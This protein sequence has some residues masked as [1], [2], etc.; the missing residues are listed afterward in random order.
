MIKSQTKDKLMQLKLNAFVEVLEEIT[1]NTSCSLS[2][3]EALDM[4][5][6]REMVLRDN[7]RL[8]RLLKTAKLRYPSACA[9]NIDYHQ[10]RQ[11][12][13]E[14]LRQLTHCQ[15]ISERRNVIFTGPTGTGK[16]YLACAIG[17]QA[18]Q[19]SHSVRY[20]RVT[21]L[22][23]LLRL[24]HADGSYN[25]LL[26]RLSKIAVLILDDWG[27]DRLDRQGRRD[28]L[29]VLE[30]RYDKSSTIITTQLPAGSWHSFIGDDT[31]ADAVCDRIV[32]NAYVL[33]VQGESMRKIKDL[34]DGGQVV[35]S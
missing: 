23:E 15:W 31:I 11:F 13:Q 2:V 27:I 9:I 28:L 29:E 10:K 33:E 22:I 35:S 17:H 6:D 19:M 18:C 16:S 7:R 30:D 21:R 34:T 24:S 3:G 26:E 32:N 8:V 5:V 20:Y 12:N 25:K 14:L 1:A 4:M